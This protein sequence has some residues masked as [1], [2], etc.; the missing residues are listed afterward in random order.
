M[1]PSCLGFLFLSAPNLVESRLQTLPVLTAPVRHCRPPKISFPTP[2]FMPKAVPVDEILHFNVLCYP[3]PSS[4]LLSLPSPIFRAGGTAGRE[5]SWKGTEG[6]FPPLPAPLAQGFGG[7]VTP[8][9]NPQTG[10][11]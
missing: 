9:S 7:D 6:H 1:F 5:N 2:V 4:S 11:K 3:S 8:D 10:I